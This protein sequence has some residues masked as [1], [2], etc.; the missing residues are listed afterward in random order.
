M[1]K[2]YGE[3]VGFSPDALDAYVREKLKDRPQFFKGETRATQAMVTAKW[4]QDN[5][6]CALLNES[7]GDAS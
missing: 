7:F 4:C 6:C 2:S 5:I 1:T 3:R